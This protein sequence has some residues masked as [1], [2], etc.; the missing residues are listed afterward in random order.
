MEKYYLIII[1]RFVDETQAISKAIFEYDNREDA[2][3]RYHN[4]IAYAMSNTAIKSI[5]VDIMDQF[6][7]EE[8][9]HKEYWER[10]DIP[11]E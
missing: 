7:N 4:E 2:I 9:N 10:F 11:E 1:Q 6:G 3:V 5:F 8:A